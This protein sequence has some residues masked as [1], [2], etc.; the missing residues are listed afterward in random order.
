MEKEKFKCPNCDFGYWVEDRNIFECPN[1]QQ[2]AEIDNIWERKELLEKD[3][4]YKTC[5]N[6]SYDILDDEGDVMEHYC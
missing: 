3:D 4:K 5:N 6:C 2:L 1:C